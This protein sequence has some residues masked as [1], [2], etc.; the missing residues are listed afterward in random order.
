MSQKN[1]ALNS[2]YFPGEFV[3]QTTPYGEPHSYSFSSDSWNHEQ[4]GPP[5]SMEEYRINTG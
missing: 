2:N 3:M 1:A 5:D 4:S